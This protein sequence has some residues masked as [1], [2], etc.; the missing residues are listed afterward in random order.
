MNILKKF[1]FNKETPKPNYI[2]N[3]NIHKNKLN[4]IPLKNN[5]IKNI[6]QA[7]KKANYNNIKNIDLISSKNNN[8]Q[9]LSNAI[10]LNYP[11]NNN[12][13]IIINK[14]TFGI[15]NK[16]PQ[17]IINI[18]RKREGELKISSNE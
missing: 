11:I 9:Q 16:K 7:N 12:N 13:N 1:G 6:Y 8:Y 3:K 15:N 10:N 5:N 2:N 18:E 17:K 4:I 14:D